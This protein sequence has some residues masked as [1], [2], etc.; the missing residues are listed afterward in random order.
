MVRQVFKVSKF[1][2]FNGSL[3][4][5][6]CYISPRIAFDCFRFNLRFSNVIKRSLKKKLPQE[7]VRDVCRSNKSVAAKKEKVENDKPLGKKL[8]VD[9]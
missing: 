1:S 9:D 7:R 8:P 2:W 6:I 5:H 4:C 3:S